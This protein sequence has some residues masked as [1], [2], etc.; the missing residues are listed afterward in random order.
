M[1][2][3]TKKQAGIL[4]CYYDAVKGKYAEFQRCAKKKQGMTKEERQR[5]RAV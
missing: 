5:K 3:K 4:T 1:E 2:R